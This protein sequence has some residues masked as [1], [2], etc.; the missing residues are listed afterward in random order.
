MGWDRRDKGR[1]V[2]ME[3]ECDPVGQGDRRRRDGQFHNPIR[4]AIARPA[5]AVAGPADAFAKNYTGRMDISRVHCGPAPG[6]QNSNR[7]SN[8]WLDSSGDISMTTIEW[9]GLFIFFFLI[10]YV[11]MDIVGVF[12]WRK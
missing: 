4:L 10:G 5:V 8:S 2:P 7:Q 11:A 3:F 9:V 6:V 1:A 12:G